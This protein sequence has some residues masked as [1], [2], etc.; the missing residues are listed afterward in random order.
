MTIIDPNR[1]NAL[2]E[3]YL[4]KIDKIDPLGDNI[5]SSVSGVAY[6]DNATVVDIYETTDFK[7]LCEL[8]R[9]WFEAGYYASDAAT[10][11]ATT[12][13]LLMSGNCFGTFCG[14]GNPKIAQQ[15]TNNYGHPFENVQISDSMIWSGNGG[16]WMVNSSCKDPSAAC[17]FMNLL[18]TDAYVDNLL[19]YGEE[20]VDYKLDE[21]GCAVAPDGYTDLNSVAYT[22]NMN[23]Y[24]WGNKWLTYPV[25]GGLYGEEKETNKQ[26]NYDGD[27][28]NYYGFLYD[29]SDKEAEYTACLNI[30]AEYK[31]VSVGW[32]SRCRYNTCRDDKTTESSRHG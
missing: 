2:F 32:C 25:A 16:A 27:H 23:Y 15:Y 20:G 17:K 22:D 6:Q 24:F 26:Q 10:T 29:Y 1:A 14:L 5:A 4:G 3:S 7:E 8:T 13:E 21:N 28:S 19:V 18:Y 9:S 30:V 12:A 31:K 11:T